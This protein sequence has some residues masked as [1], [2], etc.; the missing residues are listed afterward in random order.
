MRTMIKIHQQ[1]IE[2]FIIDFKNMTL[3]QFILHIFVSGVAFGMES[4]VNK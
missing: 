4:K 3:E 1:I 2:P